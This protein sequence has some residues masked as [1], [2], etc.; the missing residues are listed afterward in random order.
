MSG[1]ACMVAVGGCTYRGELSRGAGGL[2]PG[3]GAGL[4][5]RLLREQSVRTRLDQATEFLLNDYRPRR[6]GAVERR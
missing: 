1:Y 4:E 2:P 5:V 3:G 6:F